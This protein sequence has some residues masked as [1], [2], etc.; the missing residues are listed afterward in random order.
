MT[1]TIRI[2]NQVLPRTIISKKIGQTD[3]VY[4]CT[5][6]PC[7][8][9]VRRTTT[10]GHDIVLKGNVSD[11]CI[12]DSDDVNKRRYTMNKPTTTGRKVRRWGAKH[13]NG[14]GPFMGE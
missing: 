1:S 9:P 14:T 7:C 3:I 12:A 8:A 11:R 6:D 2:C 13:H 10:G 4:D 5:L